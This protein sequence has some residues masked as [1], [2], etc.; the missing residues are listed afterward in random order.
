[1]PKHIV[2]RNGQ[3]PLSEAL[4]YGSK[5]VRVPTLLIL[6]RLRQVELKLRDSDCYASTFSIVAPGAFF[7]TLSIPFM[8]A[9]FDL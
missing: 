1:M 6:S 2:R 4:F 8:Q 9:P 5:S 7:F 3:K